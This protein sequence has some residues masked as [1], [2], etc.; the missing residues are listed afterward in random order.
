MLGRRAP[1]SPIVQH[2]GRVHNVR[3]IAS[4]AT[5]QESGV[6]AYF[7]KNSISHP[8]YRLLSSK[9]FAPTRLTFISTRYSGPK[10]NVCAGKS[11]AYYYCITG[12]CP[13]W[14]AQPIQKILPLKAKANC[15]PYLPTGAYLPTYLWD[16]SSISSFFRPSSRETCAHP[17][18]IMIISP[19]GK[20]HPAATATAK[21]NKSSVYYTL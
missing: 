16:E 12:S 11:I 2:I 9:Q 19:T 10:P 7:A 20:S 18:M 1:T 8:K 15:S 14:G 5:V 17:T 3:G 21:K 13:S 6:V 4:N